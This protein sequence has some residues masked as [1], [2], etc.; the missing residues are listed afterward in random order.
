MNISFES[1]S[2]FLDVNKKKNDNT[3]WY[4]RLMYFL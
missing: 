1:S 2:Q 3:E 4:L